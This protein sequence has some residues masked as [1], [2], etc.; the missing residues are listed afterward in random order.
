M[1]LELDTHN[2]RVVKARLGA[3]LAGF[4]LLFVKLSIWILIAIGI[5][6]ILINWPLGWL[7]MSLAAL[8]FMLER[9]YEGG[10]KRVP[11]IKGSDKI[12]DRLSGD[13][14]GRLSDNPTPKMIA[15]AAE[16]VVG[17]QFFA[18]RF[19]LTAN[20]MSNI[21]NDNQNDSQAVWQTA[22]KLADKLDRDEITPGILIYSLVKNYPDHEM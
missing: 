8:P 2:M 19:G 20:L 21:T 10:L 5:C 18:A 12:G 7:V 13:I 17:G 9:W 3:S 1:E 6:L 11:V 22:V 14:L 15:S 4:W 16:S